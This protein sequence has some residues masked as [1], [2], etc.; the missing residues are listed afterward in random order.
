[1]RAKLLAGFFLIAMPAAAQF[2][3]LQPLNLKEVDPALSDDMFGTWEIRDATGKKRCRIV[4]QKDLA[5]G[6]YAIEVADNCKKVFPIMDE[7]AGWRLLENWT[8]DLID[9]TR[10]TRVRFQTPDERYVAIPEVDGIETLVKP[11]KKK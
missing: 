2:A 3:P 10:R 1:M 8:V 5:I 7:I 6:G 4:L 11:Q 9:A